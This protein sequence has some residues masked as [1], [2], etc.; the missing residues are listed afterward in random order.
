[1]LLRKG[2]VTLIQNHYLFANNNNLLLVSYLPSSNCAF[3]F[4][5]SFWNSRSKAS[6]GS[7]LILALFL[8]FFARLAYLNIE[9]NTL[10]FYFII[11]L[12][13]YLMLKTY[14]T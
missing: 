2:L 13:I 9:K 11:L 5:I 8:M 7:S 6:F 4:S 12:L 3:N 10:I 14:R 1:M